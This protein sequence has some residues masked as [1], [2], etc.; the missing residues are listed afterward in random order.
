[1]SSTDVTLD[2][3]NTP[4]FTSCLLDAEV[5]LGPH[6]RPLRE[7]TI[8]QGIQLL[9]TGRVQHHIGLTRDVQI[10]YQV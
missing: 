3:A 5:R 7:N 9:L 4:D 8:K 10:V 6:M 2:D 1:M